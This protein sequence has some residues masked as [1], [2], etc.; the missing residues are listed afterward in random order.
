MYI[1]LASAS[2]SVGWI[3]DGL[4]PLLSIS[5][6]Q[7]NERLR[8]APFGYAHNGGRVQ[9]LIRGVLPQ[10]KTSIYLLDVDRLAPAGRPLRRFA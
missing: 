5:P 10:S 8:L 9:G 6:A 4:E 2:G 1:V 7:M 3:V